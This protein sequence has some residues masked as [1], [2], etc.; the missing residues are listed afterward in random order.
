MILQFAGPEDSRNKFEILRTILTF[1]K[2]TGKWLHEC[3]CV[4]VSLFIR[5][6]AS[7]QDQHHMKKRAETFNK[8]TKFPE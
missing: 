3:A 1:R 5:C 8:R 7:Q 6:M 4:S 2:T